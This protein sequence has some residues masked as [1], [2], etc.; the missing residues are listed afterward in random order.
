MV[1]LINHN[2][3]GF[4]V[5]QLKHQTIKKHVNKRPITA[6]GSAVTILRLKWTKHKDKQRQVSSLRL[7]CMQVGRQGRKDRQVY[8]YRQ[9][10]RQ[11]IVGNQRLVCR[12]GWIGRR[13]G[14]R[15]RERRRRGR[16]VGEVGR[17]RRREGGRKWEN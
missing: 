10:G 12:Q 11:R 14:G 16:Q 8:N 7:V 4:K 15:E 9:V 13:E 1:A 5:Q 2:S 3:L 6:P 17:K